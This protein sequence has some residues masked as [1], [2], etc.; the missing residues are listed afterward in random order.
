MCEWNECNSSLISTMSLLIYFLP[1]ELNT[2]KVIRASVV[3]TNKK[4]IYSIIIHIYT[5]YS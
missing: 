1:F 4:T 3:K 2:Y 5:L